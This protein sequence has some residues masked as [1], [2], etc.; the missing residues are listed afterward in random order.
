MKRS[1]FF[2]YLGL[3]VI[4][5]SNATNDNP[6]FKNDR[7]NVTVGTEHFTHQSQ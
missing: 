3:L 7:T 4:T 1:T 5:S 2:S 6:I